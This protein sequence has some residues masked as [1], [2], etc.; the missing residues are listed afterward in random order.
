MVKC[1]VWLRRHNT[2]QQQRKKLPKGA[3]LNPRH[4][5]SPALNSS[6]SPRRGEKSATSPNRRENDRIW[7]ST[8]KTAARMQFFGALLMSRTWSSSVLFRSIS[9]KKLL[10]AIS[11]GFLPDEVEF[12]DA[13]RPFPKKIRGTAGRAFFFRANPRGTAGKTPQKTGHCLGGVLESFASG[14]VFEKCSQKIAPLYLYLQR[15]CS[16]LHSSNG[17]PSQ[18]CCW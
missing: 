5:Q 4:S 10:S 15:R 14:G 7:P 12:C 13:S 18:P 17:R 6:R 11:M 16:S 1:G 2:K 9:P 8:H 3:M